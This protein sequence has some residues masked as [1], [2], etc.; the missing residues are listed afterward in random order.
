M[1]K[2][3]DYIY[4][5]WLVLRC[6][7][8]DADALAELIDRWHNRLRRVVWRLTDGHPD[9]PDIVQEVWM[10]V[11][12]RMN[13]LEDPAAFPHW[14]YRI[15]SAKCADWVRRRG[16]D[17]SLKHAVAEESSERSDHPAGSGD[18][19]VVRR[20]LQRLPEDQRLILTLFYLD[21]LSTVEIAEAFEIPVGTVKS[22]L[23][24]ARNQ[25]RMQIERS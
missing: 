6:Q 17:R 9:G 22:R 1:E 23:F 18:R 2:K 16:R 21:E 15:A 24:R 12:R 7:G 5:Q 13:R 11:V 14:L 4:D 25:L 19:A 8:G 3:S 20:A 10:T